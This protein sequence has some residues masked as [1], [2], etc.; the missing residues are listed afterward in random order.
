VVSVRITNTGPIRDV[1]YTAATAD[2]AKQIPPNLE[3]SFKF[4]VAVAGKTSCGAPIAFT[5]GVKDFDPAARE[6]PHLGPK[7]A[8]LRRAV[9]VDGNSFTAR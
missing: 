5:Q 4:L 1:I 3:V 2:N 6:L 8:D 9:A 7:S